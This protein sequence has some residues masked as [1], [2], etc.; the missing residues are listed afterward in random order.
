MLTK[1]IE[2]ALSNRL[3]VIAS[4]LMVAALGVYN[5]LRIPIDAVPDMTNTQ[6][7]ILTDAGSLSPIEVEQYVSYPVEATMVGIARRR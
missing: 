4:V 1:L 3:L 6:V 5:A 7:Q 2:F